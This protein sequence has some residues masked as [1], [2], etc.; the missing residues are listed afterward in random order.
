MILGSENCV[1]CRRLETDTF[2]GADVKKALAGRVLVRVNVD[3]QPDVGRVLGVTSVPDLRLFTFDGL[4][5]ARTKGYLPPAEFR[6][7]VK[8]AAKESPSLTSPSLKSLRP[9]PALDPFFKLEDAGELSGNKDWVRLLALA[10]GPSGETRAE[11]LR[12]VTRWAPLRRKALVAALR[13]RLLKV[14]LAACEAL[15]DVGAPLEG[16]EPYAGPLKSEPAA[17][18]TWLEFAAKHP[19]VVL[20]AL[21]A[22]TESDLVLIEDG[23]PRANG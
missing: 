8:I 23:P 7:W 11:S 2:Q 4:A 1:W 13:H 5:L 21:H 6:E 3:A 19:S 15:W 10:A 16:V 20:A 14:R 18:V 9:A 17:L 12:L 22:V